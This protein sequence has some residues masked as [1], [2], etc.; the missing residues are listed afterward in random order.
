[1]KVIEQFIRS[2][3]GDDSTGEDGIFINDDFLTVIDGS[4]NQVKATYNG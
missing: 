3:T 1:M 4:S 2:K